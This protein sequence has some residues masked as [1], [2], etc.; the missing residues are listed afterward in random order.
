MVRACTFATRLSVWTMSN[1]LMERLVFTLRGEE[2]KKL[3]EPKPSHLFLLSK[4][5]SSLANSLARYFCA[6]AN[7]P[8]VQGTKWKDLNLGHWEHPRRSFM[9]GNVSK[10]MRAILAQTNYVTKRVGECNEGKNLSLR[11]QGSD[12]VVEV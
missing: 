5:M 9:L 11:A 10:I 7:P 6:F 8:R 1:H 12:C 2:Q 3:H 4:A